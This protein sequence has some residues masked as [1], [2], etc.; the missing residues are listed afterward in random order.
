M[1]ANLCDAER[2]YFTTEDTEDTE[3]EKIGSAITLADH[4][5][6]ILLIMTCPAGAAIP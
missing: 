6:P 3:R 2:V 1:I 5:L 4:F